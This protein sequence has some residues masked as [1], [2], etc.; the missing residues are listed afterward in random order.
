MGRDVESPEAALLFFC[1]LFFSPVV[2][3]HVT[4]NSLVVLQPLPVPAGEHGSQVVV[5]GGLLGGVL[6]RP[7]GADC[8]RGLP[9]TL[10]HQPRLGA[11]A[12]QRVPDGAVGEVVPAGQH[13]QPGRECKLEDGRQPLEIL[14]VE[15]ARG[16]VTVV[17]AGHALSIFIVEQVW[18]S[19]TVVDSGHVLP[20][21]IN[22]VT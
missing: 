20:V 11:A 10:H 21:E 6:G 7:R 1:V 14:I 5:Q 2:F 9:A 4:Q 8:G 16:I 17:D 13:D 22:L 19:I 15:R 12:T 3:M 18:Q